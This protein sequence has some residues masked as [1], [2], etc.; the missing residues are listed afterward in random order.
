MPP[1]PKRRRIICCLCGPN[2]KASASDHRIK[3]NIPHH[4]KEHYGRKSIQ[5]KD[6]GAPANPFAFAALARSKASDS[7]GNDTVMT[8]IEDTATSTNP[9][10]TEI[11]CQQEKDLETIDHEEQEHMEQGVLNEDGR[12]NTDDFLCCSLVDT[13]VEFP[14]DP[15]YFSEVPISPELVAEILKV[16]PCQPGKTAIFKFPE[17]E[18]G[19]SFCKDWYKTHD[20]KYD[21]D[22]LIYSPLK[23]KMYCLACWLFPCK[24]FPLFREHW[25]NPDL[26]I[27]KWKKGAEKLAKHE[28]SAAHLASVGM[29]MQTRLHLL[30]ERGICAEQWRAHK[31]KFE[32]NR[33]IMKRLIDVTLFLASQNIS[34]RGNT[35]AS[36]R[37]G[38]DVNEGNF[39]EACKFL[40][41]YDKVTKDHLERSKGNERYTSS[42]IQND[43]IAS[44]ASIM[45]EKVLK[46][47][48][49]NKLFTL[50][51]DGS[52]D[53]SKRNQLSFN[54]RYVDME[55][56]VVD[57]NFI[58][59]HNMKDKENAKNLFECVIEMMKDWGLDFNN[60]RGQ[61][62]DGAAV[63]A[64]EKS[65]LRTRLQE[66]NKHA[67][68]IHCNAHNLNLVMSAV[69]EGN[70]SS[71]KFFTT[72]S[73]LYS[74]VM[75]AR[76][77]L[78]ALWSHCD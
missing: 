77:R 52:T 78:Y 2:S 44:A 36:G 65:G 14:T 15:A 25:A 11:P 5:F 46:S 27:N 57:E 6:E 53:I 18:D 30:K 33:Q 61:G 16:G 19:R 42:S 47:I 66:L 55:N 68:Y 71:K 7:D 75:N 63:M 17:E 10:G 76:N 37:R 12:G 62:Y 35:E 4:P 26:G 74:F 29:M 50:I 22:W 24:E 48:K 28:G 51:I 31:N 70:E 38:V 40:G 72:L 8:E 45:K 13:S 1:K 21:R 43:I 59:L 56:G 3:D 58:L 73:G 60:C 9:E 34:F 20:G 64:G 67:I 41:K 32:E 23:N 69:C 54:I 39:L 49:D